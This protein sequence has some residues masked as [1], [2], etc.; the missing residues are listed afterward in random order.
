MCGIVGYIGKR[1]AYPILIKGLKR[2]EY[3][4]LTSIKRKGKL[5]IWRHFVQIRIRLDQLE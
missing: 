1:E 5:L 3:R 4:G 2:L